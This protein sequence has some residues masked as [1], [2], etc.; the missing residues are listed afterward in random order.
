MLCHN[1]LCDWKDVNRG[2]TEGSVSGPYSFNLF[3][4]DLDVTQYCQ[5]SDLTKYA[6]DTSIFVTVRKNSVDETQKALNAFLE[7]TEANGMSCN[8]TKYKELCMAKEGVTPNFPQLSGIEQSDSLT[9]LGVTLQNDC[10][11]SS[12]VKGKLREAN[13]CLYILRSLRKDG[14]T[15]VEIDHL[16]KAIV[17]P[18]ITYALPVYGAR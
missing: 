5:A 12:H 4:N 1:T 18:K 9:L 10:K 16:F 14:Y 7:W 15:Q 3:L 2:T 6:D 8:T 17:L 11:F 13:K